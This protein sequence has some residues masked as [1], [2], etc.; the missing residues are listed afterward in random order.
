MFAK[1][2]EPYTGYFE[3]NSPHGLSWATMRAAFWWTAIAFCVFFVQPAFA[4]PIPEGVVFRGIQVVVWSQRIEVR[5]QLGLSDNMIRQ[6]LQSLL[7]ADAPI[8]EDSGKALRVYRDEMFPRLPEKLSVTVDHRPQ[9]LRLR[10]ADVIRQHHIQIELVYRIDFEVPVEPVYFLLVD[11]NFRGMP[12]YHLAAIRSR[13]LVDIPEANAVPVLSRLSR[14]PETEEDLRILSTPVRRIEAMMA[15]IE[16][17]PSASSAG[18]ALASATNLPGSPSDQPIS[19]E[20]QFGSIPPADDRAPPQPTSV[21]TQRSAQAA[22]SAPSPSVGKV[23]H[24]TPADH[25]PWIWPTVGGLFM[26]AALL[27]MVVI[28][29]RS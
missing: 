23:M 28:A 27:W 14:D 22:P 7:G 24:A 1:L 6:E 25:Q 17:E 11:D 29:R 18:E 10:R 16:P 2:D 20:S 15:A 5:Y 19:P 3:N 4:H 26:L 8:P 13:G 12:G 21:P 9:E